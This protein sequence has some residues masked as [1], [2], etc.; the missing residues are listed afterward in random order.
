MG[1]ED[2]NKPLITVSV[3]TYNSAD[4]VIETLDS[5]KAQTYR[6]I[7]LIISDDKSQDDTEEK[8]RD[9]LDKNASFFVHVQF[10]TVAH[11]TG[12]TCNCNRALFAARG[13]WMKDH[14]ADDILVPNAIESFVDYINIHPDAKAVFGNIN[15]FE[16]DYNKEKDLKKY[17][18]RFSTLC[19]G[20][21]SNAR[22]QY[23]ILSRHYIGCAPAF[24][25]NTSVA[26]SLGGY[27]ERFPTIED[28]PMYLRLTKNGYKLFFLPTVVVHQRVHSDSISN[29]RNE[30][31]LITNAEVRNVV[32]YH[33]LFH[34]ENSGV[35]WKMMSRYYQKI[36]LNVVK[37]G[38]TRQSMRSRFWFFVR[39]W[40]N[41]YK[42]DLIA[43]S[44]AD[45]FLSLFPRFR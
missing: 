6:N 38:N 11:N 39:R 34:Y 20:R 45:T 23:R 18:L 4:Y 24:F 40:L 17:S 35:F 25:V 42:Y 26:K 16:T 28:S 9:W 10:I 44:I 41:P 22:L 29:S 8:C 36:T 15:T 27:D 1:N 19:F 33:D 5:I 21:L 2:K 31:S 43:L 12:V 13:E 14:A 37:Y 32:V 3:L 7:E 30:D